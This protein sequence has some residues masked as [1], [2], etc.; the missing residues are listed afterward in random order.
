MPRLGTF[1]PSTMRPLIWPL[2]A[3]CILAA[4]CQPSGDSVIEPKNSAD[5]IPW[6]LRINYKA[7]TMKVGDALQLKATPTTVDGVPIEG[8]PAPVWTTNDTA[9]KVDANGN[10][11]T[12]QAVRGDFVVATITDPNHTWILTDTA[13]VSTVDTVYHFSGY[14]LWLQQPAQTDTV[15][16]MAVA[17]NFNAVLLGPTGQPLTDQTGA[18]ISPNATYTTNAPYPDFQ[19]FISPY[20]RATAYNIGVYKV[21]I[22]SYL[23]GTV[24]TDS[25]TFRIVWPLTVTLNIQ[26]MVPGAGNPTPSRMSQTNITITTGGTVNFLNQNTTVPADIVFDDQAHVTGGNIPVVRTSSPGSSVVFPNPGNFT[27]HSSLGFSG[28]ITVVSP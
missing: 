25:V 21:R 6:F 16:P 2:L 19:V 20:P 24:Y 27:Y 13:V 3:A 7:V 8:L 11:T 12:H 5:S 14:K 17:N 15:I 18:L 22:N 10:M 23:F 9:L 26:P 28:T 4:G 1:Q